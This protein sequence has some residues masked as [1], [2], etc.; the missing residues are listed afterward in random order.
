MKRKLGWF[1]G[2]VMAGTFL[3]GCV[4]VVDPFSGP[5]VSGPGVIIGPPVVVAPRPRGWHGHNGYGRQRGG[6]R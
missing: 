1:L 5:Y 6:Y 3:G 4:A 2:F